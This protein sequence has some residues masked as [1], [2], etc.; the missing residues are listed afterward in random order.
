MTRVG[1]ALVGAIL[2]S[3]SGDPPGK[4]SSPASPPDASAPAGPTAAA[5]ASAAMTADKRT[6]VDLVLDLPPGLVLGADTR[7]EVPSRIPSAPPS[8]EYFR[9]YGDGG[10]PHLFFFTW[11]GFPTRD[12]GPMQAVE[13]W[14][15]AIDS[16][17]AD[18]S[19]TSHFFGQAQEVLVAHFEGPPP[20]K[21]RYMI[22]TTRLDRAAFEALLRSIA[23]SPR[24]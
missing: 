20:A 6:F 5:D 13:S 14:K 21:R 4:V 17:E 2:L 22:Y 10:E 7:E 9:S 15:L 12:R 16:A 11:D 8:A 19:R 24:P 23:F 18:I 3:C 1:P